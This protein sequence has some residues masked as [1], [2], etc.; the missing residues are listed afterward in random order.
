MFLESNSRQ[1]IHIICIKCACS[2]QS[3][4]PPFKYLQQL[5]QFRDILIPVPKLGL[6]WR[7]LPNYINWRG[8]F[9][10]AFCLWKQASK[11]S[12]SPYA[13]LSSLATSTQRLHSS[14]FKYVWSFTNWSISL[15]FLLFWV[16]S[17]MSD[18]S[19]TRTFH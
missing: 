5:I 1:T 13:K 11:L 17:H 18:P 4:L 8:P 19:Q 12:W 10:M 14:F 16:S 6:S 3:T 15:T 7:V 2:K 9:P